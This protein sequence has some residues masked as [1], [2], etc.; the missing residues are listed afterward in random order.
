MK[1]LL[2]IA[3]ALSISMSACAT[4]AQTTDNPLGTLLGGIA[5]NKSGSGDSGSGSS[6]GNLLGGLVNG[7]LG[8]D[9]ISP[10]RLVGTWNYSGPAVCFKSENFLQKAGG[11]AAASAI[12]A[13]MEP[14][15]NKL[16]LNKMQLVVKDD[17]TFTMTSGLI[18]MSGNVT[19]DGED[20]YF[21]FSALGSIPLGKMKTYITMG[22]TGKE[23][24]LMFDVSKLVSILK[25]IGGATNLK[26][27]NT[28]T[29]ILD[30]YDG[31]CAGFKLKKQ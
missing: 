5:N 29:G 20:V 17:Q 12:E 7:L 22:A 19:I 15:Y 25:T 27:V 10:E 31:V 8:T 23:M 1:Q 6:V 13:K 18:K 4:P 26:S 24:S 3:A 11:S 9:K 14:T 2:T 28:V 16:G 30:S 21:N